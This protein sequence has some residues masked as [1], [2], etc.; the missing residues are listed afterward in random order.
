MLLSAHG[1]HPMDA[2]VAEYVPA[3][4]APHGPLPDSALDLPA[5]HAE[6][7]VPPVY[8]PLH[9]HWVLPAGE[10]AFD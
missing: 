3:S 8:P 6:Q 9:A 5:A 1:E 7:E 4:H 10:S 2:A